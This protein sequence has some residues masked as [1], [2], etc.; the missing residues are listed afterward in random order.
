MTENITRNDIAES[1]FDEIGLSRSEC[2]QFVDDI[3]DIVIQ[4]IIE[5]GLVKVAGFGTFKLRHKKER[6]GRNPRTKEPAVISSRNV[7]LFKVSQQLK[8]KINSEQ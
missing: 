4:G 1:I 7:I 5:D 8:D 2:N 3:I 6:I